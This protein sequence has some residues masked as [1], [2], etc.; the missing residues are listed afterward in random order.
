MNIGRLDQYNLNQAAVE[1]PQVG[2]YWHEMFSPYFLI[3]HVNKDKYTIL[4]C[5]SSYSPCAKKPVG[6]THWTFDVS[7]SMEVDHAWMADRVKYSS[8]D[9]FVADV[10]RNSCADIIEEWTEF[11]ARELLKQL[12]ELGPGVT[13][14]LLQRETT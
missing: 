2:D 6:D 12:D 7:Q 11:R 3:V 5:M 8:I 4:N 13:K 10:R 9:G 1:N 14:Y